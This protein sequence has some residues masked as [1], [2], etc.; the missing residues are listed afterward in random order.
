LVPSTLPSTFCNFKSRRISSIL[1]WP[2]WALSTGGTYTHLQASTHIPH[3][4][5]KEE[6]KRGTERE[7]DRERH[8]ERDYIYPSLPEGRQLTKTFPDPLE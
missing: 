2:P 3:T 8:K 4:C 1:Y 7:R 6:R 5:K